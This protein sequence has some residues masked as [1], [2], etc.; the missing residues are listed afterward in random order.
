MAARSSCVGRRESTARYLA[1]VGRRKGE[2]LYDIPPTEEEDDGDSTIAYDSG[3]DTAPY[4][5]D[6]DAPDD[7]VAVLGRD[8]G[9][10]KEEVAGALQRRGRQE[11]LRRPLRRRGGGRR[12]VNKA[13]RDAGLEGERR[14]NAVDATGALVPKRSGASH[15]TRILTARPRRRRR[16]GPAARADGDDVGVLG[17]DLGQ[18]EPTVERRNTKTRTARSEALDA[19]TST[20]R[21]RPRSRTPSTRPSAARASKAAASVVTR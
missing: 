17:R 4:D 2:A 21:S 10:E 18:E 6:G 20:P 19:A 15:Q 7:V 12:A 8:L 1:T 11:A 16:A 3:D 5:G 13:I 9:S 14:M